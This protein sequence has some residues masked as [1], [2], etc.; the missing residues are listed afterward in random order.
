[1]DDRADLRYHSDALR[2]L[3]IEPRFNPAAADQIAQAEVAC[4]RCL[5]AAVREWYSIADADGILTLDDGAC[6][7]TPLADFLRYFN[8]GRSVIEFYGPR[9]VNTGYQAFVQITVTD[10]PPVMV[11]GDYA[12]V[13]FAEYVRGLAEYKVSSGL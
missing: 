6:G 10:N 8:E 11:A 12:P 9:R 1:M 4:G 13:P 7:V 2:L 5:P 3:T